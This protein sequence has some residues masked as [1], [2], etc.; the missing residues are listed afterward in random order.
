MAVPG[1]P[2]PGFVRGFLLW[3]GRRVRFGPEHGDGFDFNQQLGPA[4]NGLNPRGSRKRVEF[5]LRVKSG[6]LLVE[7]G[8]I[9]FDVA[10]VAGGPDHVLP[11]GAF[12]LEQTGDVLERAAGL[13]LEIADVNTV[14][15][16]IDR[17]EER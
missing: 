3:C 4:K 7:G 17:S 9:A 12:R 11:G 6:A 5:L 1:L 13:R 15:I 10:Q 16:L 2:S 14:P 8:V